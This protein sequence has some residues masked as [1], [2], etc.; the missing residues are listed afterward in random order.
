MDGGVTVRGI[1]L[2]FILLFA[3]NNNA[4][5]QETNTGELNYQELMQ[6]QT[7]PNNAVRMSADLFI[8]RPLLIGASAA[9]TVIFVATLPFS[10]LGG[11]VGKSA[12]ELVAKPVRSAFFR[13]LGCTL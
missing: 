11:N 1:T 7:Q 4:F 10:L 12:H 13:C 5:A 3:F 2:I 9:G 6:Q 8:A